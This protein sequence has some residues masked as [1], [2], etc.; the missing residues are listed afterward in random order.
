MPSL[1]DL[2]VRINS[3]KQTRKI[4][5]AMKL[6]ASSKLKRAQNR[7]ENARP[8][9]ET[10]AKMLSNLAAGAKDMPT[11]PALLR[12]RDEVKTHLLVVA[13]AD[14]GLCG[15]FN[16]SIARGA[17]RKIQELQ[18]QGVA[19]KLLCVGRK[20]RD[21]LR[22]TYADLIVGSVDGIVGK[23]TLEFADADGIAAR[24]IDAFDSGEVD[25][26]TIIFNKFKSVISAELTFKSL[27]PVELP[28]MKSGADE[29]SGEAKAVYEYE[30]DE[31]EILEKLLPLNV[32]VQI[33]RALVENAA[34]E[35]G[36]RMAAMDN[37]T[38]NA[39]EMINKLTLVYNRQR[40]AMITK[41][42]IEIVSGAEAL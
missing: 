26:A 38:R 10:M 24:I 35:Q 36:A 23:K 31:D 37:A 20:G 42:L 13:T 27:V 11:A 15:G 33:Y 2:R 40:Q 4:T 29:T 25:A 8:F 39:G 12:G 9:S 1:K 17:R 7:A 28:E 18:A 14:R 30:P 34:S 6:V 16:A 32:A 41:E 22:R 5:S 21:N 3:V 19:V